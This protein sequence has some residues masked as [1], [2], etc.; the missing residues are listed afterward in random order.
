MDRGAAQVIGRQAAICNN[1]R[2]G[3]TVSGTATGGS[4]LDWFVRRG[5][6]VRGPLSSAK[7]RHLVLEGQI[8]L[9]DEVSDDRRAWRR[10]GGVPEVVPLQLRSDDREMA[11]EQDALSRQDRTRAVRTI[12]VSVLVLGLLTLGVSLV[13]Q[14]GAE[15]D[16][17]CAAAPAPGV[18][19][20]GCQ[21]SGAQLAAVS[22][23]DAQL[24]NASLAGASLTQADLHRADLRYADLSRADLSYASLAQ[25]NLKGANLRYADLTNADLGGADLS[26]ADLSGARIGGA[27]LQGVRLGGA[28]WID[29]RS[30]QGPD[31][32]R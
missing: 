19:L 12:I 10:L 7:V 13:G 32:P 8:A 1:H 14:R 25:A 11:A 2:L 3:N 15:D 29:G 16:R 30:C 31:C 4:G 21:L 6:E 23:A 24:A 5:A 18:S 26:F 9:D 20:E 22:L 27:R 28:V 17:D